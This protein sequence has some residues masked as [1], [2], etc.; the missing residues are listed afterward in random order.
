MNKKK[1]NLRYVDTMSKN[2]KDEVLWKLLT[3]WYDIDESL[4]PDYIIHGGMGTNFTKYPGAIKIQIV[5]ENIVPDFNVFDYAIGFDYMKFG[6][7]YVRV[8]L[9]VFYDAYQKMLSET[10]TITK[11][12]ACNRKFCCFVV[13]N[14][15][16][17]DPIRDEFFFKLNKYKKVDSAGKHL[18]NIGGGFLKDKLEFVSQYKFNIAFENC[19]S[20]GYT[21]EKIMEPMSVGT[22]PIYWGNPSVE[23]DF[24]KKSFVNLNDFQTVDDCI[25]YIIKLDNDDSL[26]FEMLNQSWMC[27]ETLINY[28]E[29]L[30]SF[31]DEIFINNGPKRR[32]NIYGRQSVLYTQLLK[33]YIHSDPT[34][35]LKHKIFKLI[36]IIKSRIHFKI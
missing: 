18:N 12:E 6:D 33:F 11:E 36:N 9:Y 8:P 19:S 29:V 15:K 31:F 28:N 27:N 10:K 13:S 24:N 32:V 5:G 14:S 16:Y 1:I 30:K 7:R 20:D 21:T 4:E 17:A 34:R 3:E 26:Y 25:D 22:I 23:K 35:A 2:Y